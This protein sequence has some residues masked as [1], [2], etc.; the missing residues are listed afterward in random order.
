MAGS[1]TAHDHRRDGQVDR[2]PILHDNASSDR[3]VNATKDD[4]ADV[5]QSPLTRIPSCLT[6]RDLSLQANQLTRPGLW[7]SGVFAPHQQGESG[8]NGGIKLDFGMRLGDPVGAGWDV[9]H[10]QTA[11]CKLSS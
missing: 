6:R 11:D 3:P 10:L 4:G 7:A 2:V 5:H 1:S 8:G 9:K